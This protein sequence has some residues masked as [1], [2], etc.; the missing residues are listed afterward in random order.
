M[1]TIAPTSQVRTTVELAL[2]GSK[3]DLTGRLFQAALLLSLL[4]ALAILIVLLASVF[5]DAWPVLSTRLGD[6]VNSNVSQLDSRTGVRQGIVGSLIL[7]GFVAVVALPLG[8]SAAIYLQE[9]ARDTSLNRLLTTNIRNLAGVPSIVYGILGLV[10]F[11]ETLRAIT[12]PDNFGRS[13]ISGGMTL[14]VLALP[15]IILITMEA[16][17]SVPTSIREA[18]YGVGAT[19]WE[20]VRSHVLPYAAPG[21]FTG[22]ILSLARAFGETAP[23]LLV[24]SVTGYLSSPA[25][26]SPLEILQGSYTALPTQ[27]FSWSRLAGDGW[28]ENTAAAIVV[29][30]AIILVVN[31]AAILLRNRYDRKW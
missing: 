27:I 3:R 2:R 16:L 29:L 22:T 17:R 8:I 18:A 5:I 1:A 26:R 20:V 6:F 9:Y 31:L 25:G 28:R 15:I 19:R 7:I 13:I 14:A 24:G 11:V 23:L 30:L 21:I 10:V 4:L 12:G